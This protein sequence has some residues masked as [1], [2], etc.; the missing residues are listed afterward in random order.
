MPSI[1]CSSSSDP[2]ISAIDRTPSNSM[3][4]SSTLTSPA[5]SM[6]YDPMWASFNMPRHVANPEN[7]NDLCFTGSWVNTTPYNVSPMHPTASGQSS[8]Q[9][10]AFK[11]T[12]QKEIPHTCCH[13]YKRQ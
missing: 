2:G 4:S 10:S 8:E 9:Q 3:E 6:N 7:P 13:K 1:V 12:A 11:C 5:P